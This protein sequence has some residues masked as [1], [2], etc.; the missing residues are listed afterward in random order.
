M[1]IATY[2]VIVFN[3]IYI[4]YILIRYYI[5]TQTIF[6]I[7]KSRHF[8][9]YHFPDGQEVEYEI[10]NVLPFDNERKRM[11]VI[12]RNPISREITLLTK[13]SDSSVI[14][15]LDPSFSCEYR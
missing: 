14:A 2:C 1:C 9:E 8:H 11:S 7:A 15:A 6:V 10:L 3:Y 13:G 5:V 4:S 12:I